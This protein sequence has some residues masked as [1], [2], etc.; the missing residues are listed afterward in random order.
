MCG[1]FA[2]FGA[3]GCLLERFQK[4]MTVVIVEAMGHATVGVPPVG[5]LEPHC[6]QYLGVHQATA[7][8]YSRGGGQNGNLGSS[9]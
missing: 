8:R 1:S 2:V 5:I 6:K 4:A 3:N 7:Y 9:V